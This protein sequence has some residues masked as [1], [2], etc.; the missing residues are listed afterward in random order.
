MATSEKSAQQDRDVERPHTGLRAVQHSAF[1]RHW[2]AI[3]E[4]GAELI[5]AAFGAAARQARRLTGP[6]SVSYDRPAVQPAP[7]PHHLAPQPSRLR[8]TVILLLLALAILF[9]EPVASLIG[10]L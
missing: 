1:A 9:A 6:V 7:R 3:D 2:L 5:T 8:A 4:G 10:R